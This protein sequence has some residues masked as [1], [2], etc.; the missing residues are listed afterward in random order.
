MN[1]EDKPMHRKVVS[2]FLIPGL[3]EFGCCGEKKKKKRI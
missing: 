2:V 3:F 1:T